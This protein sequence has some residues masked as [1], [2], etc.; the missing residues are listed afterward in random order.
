MF[1]PKEDNNELEIRESFCG[2]CIAAPLAALG[3]GSAAAGSKGNFKKG[4]K[5]L[6]WGG[7]GMVILSILVAIYFLYI[8]KCD[9]C[10]AP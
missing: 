8:K 6:L 1:K 9:K 3:A 10:I 4:K 7:L 5:I 2:A